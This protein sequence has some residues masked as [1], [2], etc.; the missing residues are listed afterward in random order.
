M[1]KKI[2][3]T[4]ALVLLAGGLVVWYV[5]ATRERFEELPELGVEGVTVPV[6]SN[7]PEPEPEPELVDL[8]PILQQLP[9]DKLLLHFPNDAYLTLLSRQEMS[10]VLGTKEEI[11]EAKVL[12]DEVYRHLERLKSEPFYG[13]I[14]TAEQNAKL[15]PI[16]GRYRVTS[17][18]TAPWVVHVLGERHRDKLVDDQILAARATGVLSELSTRVFELIGK[19][20]DLPEITTL[21]DLEQWA[22][23]ILLF[24][25]ETEYLR[26][27]GDAGLSITPGVTVF[28]RPTDRFTVLWGT[29]DSPS[30]VANLRF[31]AA[32]QLLHAYRKLW[33]EKER[34]VEMVWEDS[35]LQ[36]R[37]L[38][39]SE[40]LASLLA[41]GPEGGRLVSILR[42]EKENA[43]VNGFSLDELIGMRSR[44]ELSDLCRRKGGLAFE[45]DLRNLFDAQAWAFADFLFHF[46]DGK[47]RDRFLECVKL[48]LTEE[49]TP[50]EF[51]KTLGIADPEQ[52]KQLN[53]EWLGHVEKLIAE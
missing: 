23:Q 46:E 10:D 19:R 45:Q 36:S 51:R 44:A 9:S 18:G 1:K 22:L 35:M 25:R 41:R 26:Y 28:Y 52:F 50:E 37:H 11:E 7:E 16:L 48:D 14:C 32:H 53:E 8:R 12:L 20:M 30:R 27:L 39:T 13:A 21:P 5:I 6:R 3:V 40:G 29:L 17:A 49:L 31:V 43:L 4:G 2:A 47:Y 42:A 34:G 15:H 38:L 33:L 24:R